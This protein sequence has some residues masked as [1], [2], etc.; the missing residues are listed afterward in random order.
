LEETQKEEE[1]CE[2]VDQ[3]DELNCTT[4]TEK[5]DTNGEE[6]KKKWTRKAY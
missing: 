3:V 6:E 2:G 4:S 1:P 5:D